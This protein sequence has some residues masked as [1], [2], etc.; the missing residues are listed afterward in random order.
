MR[1]IVGALLGVTL[2]GCQAAQD[3]TPAPPETAAES[4]L[5][6]FTGGTIYTGIGAETAEAV[7]IDASG[8]IVAVSPPT[9]MDWDESEVTLIDLDG[10]VMFPG[11]VDGHAHLLGIGQRDG[12]EHRAAIPAGQIDHALPLDRAGDGVDRHARQAP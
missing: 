6:V 12:L 2:F 11:F 3:E 4:G 8:R 9:S 7:T 1:V 5:T 10:A